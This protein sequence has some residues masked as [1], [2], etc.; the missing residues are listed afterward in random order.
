MFSFI[1]FSGSQSEQTENQY[2]SADKNGIPRNKQH[3]L[4]NPFEVGNIYQDEAGVEDNKIEKHNEKF[5]GSVHLPAPSCRTVRRRRPHTAAFTSSRPFL[6][7]YH[8]AASFS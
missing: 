8:K 2:R 5:R 7:L 6:I 3:N 1:L 4:C